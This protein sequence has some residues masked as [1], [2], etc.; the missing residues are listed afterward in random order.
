MGNSWWWFSWGIL[1]WLFT[2]VSAIRTLNAQFETIA[3]FQT[4]KVVS[5]EGGCGHLIICTSEI[6]C[7]MVSLKEKGD[8][9]KGR[10]HTVTEVTVLK[11][12]FHYLSLKILLTDLS[13]SSALT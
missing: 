6:L 11:R 7:V 4:L 1:N 9:E 2:K 13:P 12:P 10:E 3:L 8:G 5:L